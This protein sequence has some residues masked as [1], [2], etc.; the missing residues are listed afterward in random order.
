MNSELAVT[1]YF[2]NAAGRLLED[3]AGFLRA[4]WST[5]PRQP[6]DTRALFTHMLAALQRHG[7]SRILINQVG[8]PPFSRDEQQWVAQQ[9]LPRAVLKGGYRY[10]AVVVSPDVMVRLAT[11]YITTNIQGLPLLYRSFERVAEAEAW[12]LQQPGTSQR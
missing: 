11:A 10:G 7:W 6:Q 12:L 5:Q 2:E 8:M 3:P 9:W 4:H 1:L